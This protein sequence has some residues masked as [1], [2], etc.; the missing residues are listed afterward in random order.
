MRKSLVEFGMTPSSR[1][2]IK[3]SDPEGAGSSPLQKML[4][5]REQRRLADRPQPVPSSV[6]YVCRRIPPDQWVPVRVQ[7]FKNSVYNFAEGSGT[8]IYLWRMESETVHLL[9]TKF[10]ELSKL[11]KLSFFILSN[12]QSTRERKKSSSRRL[13]HFPAV[14]LEVLWRSL[15]HQSGS[16]GRLSENLAD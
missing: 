1:I 2:R 15:G 10:G 6:N 9:Y 3:G 8:Q 4:R 14:D 7:R 5:A 12:L 11:S 16:S 13:H